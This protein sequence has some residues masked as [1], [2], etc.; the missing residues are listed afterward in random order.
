[1]AIIFQKKEERKARLK[2]GGQGVC[3]ERGPERYLF[4]CQPSTQP[5]VRQLRITLISWVIGE[6]VLKGKEGKKESGGM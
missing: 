3:W 2:E 1:M 4:H 5:V 6:K